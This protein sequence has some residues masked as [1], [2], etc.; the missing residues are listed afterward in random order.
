MEENGISGRARRYQARLILF[1][2]VERRESAMAAP[3]TTVWKLEPHTRAK[4]AI[5]SRYLQAWTPILTQGGFPKVAYLDGFAGPGQYEGG[6]DGSPVLA[7]KAVLSHS[8]RI[9]GQVIFVFVEEKP[10]RA[11][12]L[13]QLVRSMSLPDNFV[14]QIDGG[15][16]FER[17]FA[18]FHRAH[19]DRNGRLP[20]TFAFIDPFG[21]TGAP[22]SVVQSILAQPSCEVFVTFMYEEINRFIGHPDQEANFDAFFGTRD[23]RLGITLTNPT[24][25]NRFLHGLYLRQLKQIAGA[26]YVRSFQMRNPAGVTDYY[27][28]YAT[29]SQ[30]G[31]KKMKEAMWKVDESGEFTFSDATDPNQMVLFSKSPRFDDLQRQIVAKFASQGAS[32]GEVEEFVLAETAY[33]ETHYKRQVLKELEEANP[34]RLEIANAPA[35]RRRGT[36][37]DPSMRIRFM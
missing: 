21:W 6:E 16:T 23:W 29:N 19:A 9:R 22:F 4:H 7:L 20:P 34:S 17:A 37:S 26:K 32:V 5:L 2:P 3:K 10:E 12:F 33:R 13:R 18:D 14:V 35:K 36:F 8:T 11:E 28:F 31:L 25:R 27:L 1:D 15:R 24:E 30:I